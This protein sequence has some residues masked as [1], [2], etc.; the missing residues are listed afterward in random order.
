M[1]LRKVCFLQKDA[2]ILQQNA[3]ILQQ[4]AKNFCLA[5]ADWG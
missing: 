1:R 5:V 4:D 2:K 3:K